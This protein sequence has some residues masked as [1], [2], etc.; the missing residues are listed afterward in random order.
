MANTCFS[1]QYLILSQ[2]PIKE[3]KT[4]FSGSAGIYS[5]RGYLSASCEPVSSQCSAGNPVVTNKWVSEQG[6]SKG[7]NKELALLVWCFPQ[8]A[9]GAVSNQLCEVGKSTYLGFVSFLLAALLT[10]AK[11]QKE[12]NVC[13]SRERHGKKQSLFLSWTFWCLWHLQPQQT[14]WDHGG[15]ARTSQCTEDGRAGKWNDL[16]SLLS[17][18]SCWINQHWSHLPP[19][20]SPSDI[21]SVCLCH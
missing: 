17:L 10:I 5:F 19:D 15:P 9:T 14:T 11:R 18:L 2:A 21:L 13:R 4:Q 20:F 7:P 12:P 6:R 8:Q 3:S 16:G 1:V